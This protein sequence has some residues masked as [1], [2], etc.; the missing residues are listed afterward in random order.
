MYL[1]K[2]Y[3]G[4][5]YKEEILISDKKKAKDFRTVHSVQLGYFPD[6][7]SVDPE[8]ADY[9]ALEQYGDSEASY[10][11]GQKGALLYVTRK[12][13][14]NDSIDVVQGMVSRMARAA[15]RAHA[16]YVWN[17]WINN[18]DCPDGTAWFTSG[19]GNLGTDALDFTPLVT[20]IT[21][22]ANMTEGTPS[23]EKIGLDLADFKWHLVVPI[24]L[25]DTA[26]KKNQSESYFTSNDLTNKVPNPIHHLFGANNERI[27]VCPLLTDAND[28]GIIRDVQDVPIVEMSYLNGREDPEF[29]V[30]KDPRYEAIFKGDKW[31]HRI[32]HEYGGNLADYRGGYKSVV[33]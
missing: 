32:R 2:E 23:N 8:A 24:D 12:H 10:A 29:L 31:P 11:I 14:L 19:H 4:F 30:E 20:A 25:W 28:W 9:M 1:S 3:R 18:S 5:P 16:R 33:T 15:R 17:F 26:V 13:I 6:L 22:L 21:A 7:P 27:A